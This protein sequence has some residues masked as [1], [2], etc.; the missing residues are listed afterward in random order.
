MRAR[1][2]F[3]GAGGWDVAARDLGWDVEGFEINVD[4]RLTRAAAGLKTSEIIDV[5]DIVGCCPCGQWDAHIASPPC[6]SFSVAGK[7]VGRRALEAVLTVIGSYFNGKPMPYQEACDLMGDE[8]TALVVEPLRLAMA[9]EP[10]YIAWE[11]VPAVLPVWKVCAE[12]LKQRKGYSAVVG[13]VNAE[14]FGVPQTRKRAILIARRDGVP[15]ELPVPTHSTYYSHTPARLDPG[16]RKWRT[17]ADALGWGMTERPYFTLA[18]ARTTG[19]PDK[20]KVGGSQARKGLYAERDAGRWIPK[21]GI[22]PDDPSIRL[23]LVEAAVLQGFDADFPWQGFSQAKLMQVGNAVPV[24]LAHAILS[25][26]SDNTG[27]KTPPSVEQVPDNCQA[28]LF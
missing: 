22:D 11:Q 25:T 9:E 28:S 13:V 27:R 17:M 23:G 20:E 18:C 8:R 14:Q 7:G 10:T 16:V 24:G 4:A 1:D 21:P 26:F 19:G 12:V 3:A 5:R 2:L 6:Q 15:A